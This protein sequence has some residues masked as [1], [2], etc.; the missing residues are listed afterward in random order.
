MI[1]RIGFISTALYFFLLSIVITSSWDSFHDL[2]PNEWGD[3]LAGSLGPLAIFWLVLGFFQQGHELRNSNRE[4]A[5]SVEALKLQAKELKNSV[6]QQRLSVAQQKAMV[7]I[8]NR[9]LDLDI[10]VREEQTLL[11]RSQELPYIQIQASGSGGVS[12]G[13]RNFRYK[14][15]NVGATLVSGDV[16]ISGTGI[17]TAEI[18]LAYMETGEVREVSVQV[19]IAA[20]GST[21]QP[22]VEFVAR[23]SN[24]RNQQRTQTFTSD[25]AEITMTSCEPPAA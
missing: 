17:A 19:E 16:R 1:S 14:L 21:G 18:G 20:L 15:R 7:D 23:A 13:K 6:E 10:E 12:A 25:S 3:F 5:N 2:D 9:Q 8:T 22:H 11:T 24:L 4:L